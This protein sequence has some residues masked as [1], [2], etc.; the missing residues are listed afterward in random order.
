MIEQLTSEESKV[1][2][3]ITYLKIGLNHVLTRLMEPPIQMP[4]Q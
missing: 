2:E 3:T 4:N 1:I